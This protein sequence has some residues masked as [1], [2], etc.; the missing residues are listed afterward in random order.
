[1][2]L[3]K[4]LL[5]SNSQHCWMLHVESVCT[6]CCMLLRVFGSCCATGQT[7][8]YGQTVATTPN[9]VGPTMLG[10]VASVCTDLMPNI[11]QPKL[12]IGITPWHCQ[13]TSSLTDALAK[14]F[15]R[16]AKRVQNSG[17]ESDTSST[18]NKASVAINPVRIRSKKTEVTHVMPTASIILQVM[19]S[20]SNL[21]M[22]ENLNSIFSTYKF[23][24]GDLQNA[25]WM[26]HVILTFIPGLEKSPI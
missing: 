25:S 23:V 17:G 24:R 7:F 11:Y 3:D 4:P 8:S 21:S 10:V 9:M 26:F 19:F 13:H 1:M 16:P 20:A 14:I 15:G 22:S 2:Q 5:A 6:S 18:P 12:I